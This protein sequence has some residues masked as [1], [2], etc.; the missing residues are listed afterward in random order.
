MRLA[1]AQLNVVVGDLD[2]NV[3]R[4]V[5]AV[6]EAER[7][8]ADVVVLPELAVTGYPP[9][10]LLLR[11]GFVHAAREA[12]D[13]VARACTQAVALVGGPAFDRDLA[14]AAFVCADGAV[15]GVYRKQFLPN[16]GVFDEHRYFA[17]RPGAPAAPARRRPR[18][19]DDLRGRL[20]AGPAGDRPRARGRDAARQPVR[21][22]VPRRQGGGPRGDAR[23]ASA[24][25]RRVRRLLQPRR[26]AGRA[27]L[28]RPLGR[29]R[30]RGRGDRPGSRASRRRC[31]SSTSTPTEALGRR[32]RDVRRRE[33]ERSR[34]EPVVATTLVLAPAQPVTA[35]VEPSV[36]PFAPEL[37][38]M[39]RRA[40]AGPLATTSRRTASA[41]W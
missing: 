8:G 25:Q 32:L 39:R 2:G 21:L 13:E 3:E 19:P 12:V 37:E 6:R 20:A 33:L 16:Y 34:E 38:Q 27:R 28:R 4:I 30:R 29:P 35:P 41:T 14:N 26:R 17:R 40:R 10:D 22:P 5:G 9:E 24:R 36:T 18:R 11:P 23:H 7:A 15:R 1:L 31:S